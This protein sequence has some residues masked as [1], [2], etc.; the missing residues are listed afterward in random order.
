MRMSGQRGGAGAGTRL[1]GAAAAVLGACAYALAIASTAGALGVPILAGP[2]IPGQKGYGHTKPATIFNGG[3]PTGLVS[4]I[5]WESWGGTQAVGS[6]IAEYMAP[7][8][9]VA[10]G[11]QEIARVVLFHLGTCHHKRAYDAIEW[12]FP[13]HGEHFRPHHYIDSCSGNYVE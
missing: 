8:Q 3:D 12:Y 11:S 2:W 1:R 9:S 13:Q 7:G 10:D 5:H 4:H 6:G